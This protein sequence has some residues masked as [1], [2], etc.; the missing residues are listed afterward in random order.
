M[1]CCLKIIIKTLLK[2]IHVGVFVLKMRPKRASREFK[3][4]W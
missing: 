2:G 4:Q 1:I 3:R